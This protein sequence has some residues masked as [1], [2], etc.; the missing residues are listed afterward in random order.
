MNAYS[1]LLYAFLLLTIPYVAKADDWVLAPGKGSVSPDKAFS[2]QLGGDL[3]IDC[4]PWTA[5]TAVENPEAIPTAGETFVSPDQRFSVQTTIADREFY[6]VIEDAQTG[7][8]SRLPSDY[9]PI[10][11]LEWSP[12]SKTILA[13]AHA[14]MTSLIEVLHW[15][16]HLWLQFYIDAP[17]DYDNSHVIE[18]EFKTGYIKATY[19]LDHRAENGESL[20]LY[21][22]TFHVDPTNGK[23]SE[24]V[25]TPITQ[26][27]FVSLRNSS[28]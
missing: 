5:L 11:V 6:F 24:V 9:F 28:N 21:R 2:D 22:C 19:L 18:W 8:V 1:V 3:S 25:K 16:G 13:V 12:D 10:L 15:D 27:E 23:T 14:A 7:S 4:G 26:K 17:G 20:D